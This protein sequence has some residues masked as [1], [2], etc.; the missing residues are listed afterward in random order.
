MK[1]INNSLTKFSDFIGILVLVGVIGLVVG[2]MV[3][4]AATNSL[5]PVAL[6][7][8]VLLIYVSVAALGLAAVG[9]FL[10]QTARV[11]VEGMNGNLLET[12]LSAEDI[13]FSSVGPS[14]DESGNKL[15]V[16]RAI[17]EQRLAALT[18]Y[19]RSKWEHARRPDLSDWDGS[20]KF[21]TWLRAQP[22]R[23]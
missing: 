17:H 5:D 8:A 16:D 18:S 20:I 22:D 2:V 21:A 7:L 13:T 15:P 23:W 14:R 4:F 1:N 10:R 11:I 6:G 19:E 12:D 9:A 3:F